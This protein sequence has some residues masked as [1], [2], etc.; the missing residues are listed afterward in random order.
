MYIIKQ[1]IVNEAF[2]KTLVRAGNLHLLKSIW[3]LML[4][5]DCCFFSV[6]QADTST[7]DLELGDIILTATDGLF[8]NLPE[9][10]IL[11]ELASIKART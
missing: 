11:E 3:N 9:R 8:D 1:T 6:E 4:N 10:I 2:Q 7:F 5:F